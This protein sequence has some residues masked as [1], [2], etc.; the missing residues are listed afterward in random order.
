MPQDA[1]QRKGARWARDLGGVAAEEDCGVGLSRPS[2]HAALGARGERAHGHGGGTRSLHERVG[3]GEDDIDDEGLPALEDGG[4]HPVIKGAVHDGQ[5][6]VARP[7][8]EAAD[9][10]ALDVANG[11]G[12]F[13]VRAGPVRLDVVRGAVQEIRGDGSG[14]LGHRGGGGGLERVLEP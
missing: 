5:A 3:D 8:R 4:G 11:V 12:D 9:A 6:R 7:E 14:V 2:H 1:G 10:G 13:L